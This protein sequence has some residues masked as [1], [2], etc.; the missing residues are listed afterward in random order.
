MPAT[1]PPVRPIEALPFW[2]SLLLLPLLWISALAG[3]WTL[4]LVPLF[5]W[6]VVSVGDS[7]AGLNTANP[8]PDTPESALTLHTAVT[9]A[10]PPLQFVT[11]FA[12]IGMVAYTQNLAPWEL[13]LLT[14]GF[15]ITTGGIGIVYAHEL[16]HRKSRVE[17]W[18]GDAL[19]TMALYGHFRSEHLLVHHAYVG[20]PRDAVT[21]RYNE[22]FHAFILRVLPGCLRSAWAA[23]KAKLAR[24]GLPVWDRSNPFWRYATLDLAFLLLAL[25]VGGWTGLAVFAGQAF[26]AIWHLE[27][28][29]YVEHYGLVRKHLGGGKYE[30][31]K[32]HHSWNA[33]HRLSNWLLINLQRHA[34]HHV[35]P[36]RA[37]PLLQT[38]GPEAAPQ[39]PHG[40]PLMTLMALAPPL[41]F[42]RMNPRVRRWRESF[43]PEITDWRPYNKLAT[44]LPR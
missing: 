19:M 40:Y 31:Q 42:S 14:L 41:W 21:A 25:I 38:H 22:S 11:L 35:H 17:R 37:Y 29:N 15:G 36:G 6:V 18:L 43:Y 20:T 4:F 33:A 9:L 13:A 3:G 24:K 10:W 39:L 44:P 23:E 28:V 2:L 7:I 34:D 1:R 32:P 5:A 26:I 12:I 16:M 30:P 27:L 8:D